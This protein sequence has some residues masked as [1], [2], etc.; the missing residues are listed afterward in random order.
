MTYK[1]YVTS[2]KNSSLTD[3]VKSALH[4]LDAGKAIQTD[5]RVFIKPNFTYPTYREGITTSP[6]MIEALVAAL[7]DYTIHIT[8]GES[9][10]GADVWTAD[11]TFSGHGLD[12]LVSKYGVKL[13]N[14]SRVPTEK[15]VVT[16]DGKSEAVVL[17]SL[18]LHDV[19]VFITVPVPK[20][21]AMTRVSLGFKNQWGCLP[22]AKRLRDHYR[23]PRA[24]LAINKLLQPKFAVYD[25]TYFLDRTGPMDGDA[26]RMDLLIAANDVGAG[27]LVCLRI[28]NLEAEQVEHYRLA[29]KEGMVPPS[30]DAVELNQSILPFCERRFHLERT[31]KDY[32]TLA[33]FRNRLATKIFYDSKLARPAHIVWYAIN[34]APEDYVP[35]Y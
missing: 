7:H 18:L 19:D 12:Q 16:V 3:H 10:G 31:M 8:I 34:G 28:M 1:V 30:L 20:I 9:D 26:V 25:G 17:P 27:D 5:S 21:H 33:I 29:R 2:I 6:A 23:F 35:H 22:D 32:I 24:V 13:V 4:W 11:L 14:L 15:Q